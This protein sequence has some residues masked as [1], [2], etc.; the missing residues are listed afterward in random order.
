MNKVLRQDETSPR[1]ICFFMLHVGEG[2]R[3]RD[4]VIYIQYAAVLYRPASLTHISTGQQ[5]AR[6]GSTKLGRPYVALRE[7]VEAYGTAPERSSMA[8]MPPV[9]KGT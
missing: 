3:T 5:S 7:G 4:S 9:P 6:C 2:L 1:P 8:G